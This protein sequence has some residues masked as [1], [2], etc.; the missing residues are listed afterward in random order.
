MTTIALLAAMKQHLNAMEVED[1]DDDVDNGWNEAVGEMQRAV[2]TL[3]AFL[4][5]P[6]ESTSPQSSG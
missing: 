4:S 5:P 2:D 6:V 1:P 3:T